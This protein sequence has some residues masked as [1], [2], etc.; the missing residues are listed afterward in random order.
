MIEKRVAEPKRSLTMEKLVVKFI[1][2]KQVEQKAHAMRLLAEAALITALAGE[3]KPEGTTTRVVGIHKIVVTTKLT[4]KLD[5]TTYQSLAIPADLGFV[6][7]TPSIDL[8]AFRVAE[9]AIP[10]LVAQCVTVSPAK[11]AVKIEEVTA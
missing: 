4:R 1:K 11:T 5:Y 2:A 7:F 9:A 8:K 3:I 10:E 6:T